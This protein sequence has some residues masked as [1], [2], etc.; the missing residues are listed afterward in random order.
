MIETSDYALLVGHRVMY[1]YNLNSKMK[2][3]KI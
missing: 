1:D 3:K 2:K